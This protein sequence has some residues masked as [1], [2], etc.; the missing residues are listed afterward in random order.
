MILVNKERE[1]TG[2]VSCYYEHI[3]FGKS[4]FEPQVGFEGKLT[5]FETRD[6]PDLAFQFY[7]RSLAKD[8]WEEDP[9]QLV[10]PGPGRIDAKFNW[11]C[12]QNFISIL[13]FHS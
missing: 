5:Q 10:T 1:E 13:W 3:E 9:A 7:E 2:N 8:G 6:S 4:S 12:N 11:F